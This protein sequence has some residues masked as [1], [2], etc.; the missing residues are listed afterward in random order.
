MVPPLQLPVHCML[1]RV[2]VQAETGL[3]TSKLEDFASSLAFAETAVAVDSSLAA[4][5]AVVE[6]LSTTESEQLLVKNLTAQLTAVF[7]QNFSKD[8]LLYLL[9][10]ELSEVLVRAMDRLVRVLQTQLSIQRLE[11]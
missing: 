8:P 5:F 3:R 4:D 11:R 6:V 9:A 7:E 2:A 10:S 1:L